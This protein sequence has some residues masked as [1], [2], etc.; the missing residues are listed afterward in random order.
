M[1]TVLSNVE[2]SENK[3]FY[4]S[5][6]RRSHSS[7]CRIEFKNRANDF[8]VQSLIE[9]SSTDNVVDNEPPSGKVE[10]RRSR[11]PR[12][13]VLFVCFVYRQFPAPTSTNFYSKVRTDDQTRTSSIEEK[14]RVQVISS[15]LRITEF[16]H[17]FDR[18]RSGFVTRTQ[19]KRFRVDRSTIDLTVRFVDVWTPICVSNC[20][21]KKKRFSSANTISSGTAVF[22]TASF[23]MSSI[24]VG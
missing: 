11:E 9:L 18:L 16:F 14:I 12:R 21:T 3:R 6:N 2:P 10:F 22:V 20:P 13:P 4:L 17:D 7:P 19:F 24:E 1:T 15:G 5:N 23:V 8:S